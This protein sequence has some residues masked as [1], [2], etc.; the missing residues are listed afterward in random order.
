MR[1]GATLHNHEI[2]DKSDYLRA[3][4]ESL[5]FRLRLGWRRSFAASTLEEEG[6]QAAFDKS[7]DQ[8]K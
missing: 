2:S 7:S 1:C 5:E 4:N 3:A 8:R 6:V